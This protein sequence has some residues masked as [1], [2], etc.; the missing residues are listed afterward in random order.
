MT[1]PLFNLPSAAIRLV[2]Q[3]MTSSE[4]YNLWSLSKK[5]KETVKPLYPRNTHV[6]RILNE[7]LVSIKWICQ[8]R[9]VI[10][11][12]RILLDP[13]LITFTNSLAMVTSPFSLF[14]LP[15][16]AISQVIQFMNYDE[17][18][19]LS[20][21]SKRAKHI[22]ESLNVK[23]TLVSVVVNEG[24]DVHLSIGT[25]EYLKFEYF[26][27]DKTHHAPPN[28]MWL[29]V[30]NDCELTESWRIKGLCI[31][32]W[33]DHIKTI[34][35]FSE[36]D[37]FN[38]GEDSITFDIDV[39]RDIFDNYS[40]FR[41]PFFP[42]WNS[43]PYSI[44]SSAP[45]MTTPFPLINLPRNAIRLVTQMM[46]SNELFFLWSL[47][48]KTKKEVKPLYL[49]NTYVQR[50][51]S[52]DLVLFK[53]LL[54]GEKF[55]DEL[56]EEKLTFTSPP[57]MVTSRF[58]LFNLPNKAIRQVIKFMDFDEII[59][60]SFLSK[61]AK[62][63][64]ASLEIKCDIVI[65]DIGSSIKIDISI[66]TKFTLNLEISN[67]Q[68]SDSPKAALLISETREEEDKVINSWIINGFSVKKW[69]NHI[70]SIFHFSGENYLIFCEGSVAFDMNDFRDVINSH[71]KLELEDD[72]GPESYV[73]DILKTF[74][75]TKLGLSSSLFESGKP[76]YEVLIQNYDQL[77]ICSRH[78]STITLDDLL[79][80]NS[81]YIFVSGLTI[82]EKNVNR[83]IKHWMR[84]SNPRMEQMYISF[85]GDR[86][87]DKDL[88][89]KKLN[90]VEFS[91]DQK[92]YF[93]E[94]DEP[95]FTILT[96]KGGFNISRSDGTKATI[97]FEES[98]KS[99]HIYVWHPH[100]IA[101]FDY[102]DEPQPHRAPFFN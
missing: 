38:F 58:S 86:I 10:E 36:I 74:P 45:G 95:T 78:Q 25:K 93:K 39:I 44:I 62:D 98:F 52:N 22:V 14:N 28:G 6:Q 75:T 41:N 55:K 90:Y 57:A 85:N 63:I 9:Y 11:H 19:F 1:L 43:T 17:L 71:S 40:G 42:D 77:Y 34:F 18:I 35:H 81:L 97:Q 94:K 16:K 70:K 31:K 15:D 99:L 26:N 72:C 4:L 67:S 102:S 60:L 3:M 32:K 87:I 68:T 92:R 69:L 61:R 64:A 73:M 96:I 65:I 83:L 13:D 24:I 37:Y 23:S 47:S 76:P 84:G 27:D 91:A 101:E 2:T 12:L 33:L 80:L 49:K 30:N 48:E 56:D 53:M 66:D 54:K 100:C 59:L 29:K 51:S 89:L 50:I 88:V 21:L 7:E 82:T 46:T 5:T 79:T 8:M 20:L